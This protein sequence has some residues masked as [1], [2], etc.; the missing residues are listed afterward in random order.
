MTIS[1]LTEEQESEIVRLITRGW[2]HQEIAARLGISKLKI[3]PAIKRI[4]R[5]RE[6]SGLVKV[7][8]QPPSGDA[9][10]IFRANQ[11]ASIRKCLNCDEPF[12]SKHAGNRICCKCQQQDVFRSS[13]NTCSLY[14]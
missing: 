13:P 14:L 8:S 4:N 6:L 5:L 9:K 7:A 10:A 2:T 11:S 3:T 12:H 1:T